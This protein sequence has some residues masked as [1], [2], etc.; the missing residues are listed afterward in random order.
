[1]FRPGEYPEDSP[2]HQLESALRVLRRKIRN[3]WL[4][5]DDELQFRDEI[6]HELA[7]GAQRFEQL[8]APP[9]QLW[10]RFAQQRTDQALKGLGQRGIRNI[11]F[12]L[13]ELPRCKKAT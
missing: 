1:M 13:I 2:E 9:S 6:H 4:L 7:V 5:S 10:F 8:V 12:V 11:A 3:R